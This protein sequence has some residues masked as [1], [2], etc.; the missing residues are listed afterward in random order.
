MSA[1]TSAVSSDRRRTS[2]ARS[3]RTA[4]ARCCG[5]TSR[6]PGWAARAASAAAR[7]SP[8]PE[9]GTSAATSPLAGVDVLEGLDRVGGAPLAA[10]VVVEGPDRRRGAHA[11]A[12]PG[13]IETDSCS[14]RTAA[15]FS[16]RRCCQ[17]AKPIAATVTPKSIIAIT[18]TS[19]G[20]PRWAAPKM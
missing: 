4:R 13:V 9:S 6:Q 5:G 16:A 12:I 1:V 3:A 2:S 20:I 11:L 18:L 14:G 8:A 10:D 19:T 15:I 7:I 17:V